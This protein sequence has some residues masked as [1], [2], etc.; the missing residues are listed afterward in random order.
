MRLPHLDQRIALHWGEAQQLAYAI[1]CVLAEQLSREEPA[2]VSAS[3]AL[4]FGPLTRVGNRLL[5]RARQERTSPRPTKPRVLALRY[6]E[7]AG[8]MKILPLAPT[9][10]LAWA[11]VQQASLRLERYIDFTR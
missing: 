9:A 7:V 6:D 3:L 5:A 8:L 1:E 11:Q 10:G 2:R 4:C